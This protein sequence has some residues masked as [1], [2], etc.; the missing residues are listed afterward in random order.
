[1]CFADDRI[2]NYTDRLDDHIKDGEERGDHQ[3]GDDYRTP[4]LNGRDQRTY[5]QQRGNYTP[6]FTDPPPKKRLRLLGHFRSTPLT[7]PTI[8]PTG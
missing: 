7:A 2:S 8:R 3:E 6:E 4:D 1:M 5:E